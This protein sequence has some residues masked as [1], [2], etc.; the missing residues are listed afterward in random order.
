[1]PG[2]NMCPLFGGSIVHPLFAIPLLTV[3]CSV[4]GGSS[5]TPDTLLDDTAI[6]SPSN[7][8]DPLISG[9]NHHSSASSALNREH[10]RTP[11]LSSCDSVSSA[12]S[13]KKR[14]KKTVRT[15]QNTTTLV[16]N[17]P[18]RE[19]LKSHQ[20]LLLCSEK[21]EKRKFGLC[22]SQLV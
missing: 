10:Q 7:D 1:M 2:P 12:G 16:E 18:S 17:F 3:V 4:S 9:A 11:S 6:V 13:R 21:W 8:P 19:N 20:V 15:Q 5:G 22:V 14:G